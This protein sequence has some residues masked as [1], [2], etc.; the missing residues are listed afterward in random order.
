M[1]KT[2][3]ENPFQTGNFAYFG[4]A[5]VILTFSKNIVIINME[6]KNQAKGGYIL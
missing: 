6:F 3:L 2:S 4:T 5:N 1:E